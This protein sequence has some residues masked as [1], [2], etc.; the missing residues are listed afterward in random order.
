MYFC[1][2]FSSS[3][4]EDVTQVEKVVEDDDII[5]ESKLGFI[6]TTIQLADS[7]AS[8]FAV[9]LYWDRNDFPTRVHFYGL[10]SDSS[11]CA[12][13]FLSTYETMNDPVSVFDGN[14]RQRDDY[15]KGLISGFKEK[16][17][18]VAAEREKNFQETRIAQRERAFQTIIQS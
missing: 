18:K 7:L 1:G 13:M 12:E 5:D 17:S 14:S 6:F 8:Y 2:T 11:I 15:K 9:K 4:E 10:F 3:S 16:C